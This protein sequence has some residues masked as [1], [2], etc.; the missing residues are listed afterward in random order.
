MF[1]EIQDLIRLNLN[2]NQDQHQDRRV[3]VLVLG[4]DRVH[5]RLDLGLEVRLGALDRLCLIKL[6]LIKPIL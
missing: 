2:L 3:L 1:L 4:P 6:N 5:I